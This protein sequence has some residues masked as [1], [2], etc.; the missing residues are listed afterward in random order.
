[1]RAHVEVVKSQ[2]YI[3][4]GKFCICYVASTLLSL[5]A[6]AAKLFPDHSGSCCAGQ[7]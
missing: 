6:H 1:V 5:N 3:P 2:Y 4:E 7:I